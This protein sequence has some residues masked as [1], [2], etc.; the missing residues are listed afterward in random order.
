MTAQASLWQQETPVC[1]MGDLWRLGRHTLLVGDATDPSAL[2]RLMGETRADLL[3]CDPP[4]GM[5]LDTWDN[6]LPDIPAWVGLSASYLSA[7]G[8]LLLCQVMPYVL[9]WLV[10]LEASPL[11]FKDHISWVKRMATTAMLPLNRAHESLYIYARPH[12]RYHQTKGRYTDVK[13]PGLLVDTMSLEGIDRHI[14]A[15]E[16]EI[17]S[18]EREITHAKENKH[19]AYRHMQGTK[20]VRAPEMANFTNVWSFLPNHAAH[21]PSKTQS[22]T[23]HHATVKPL[24]LVTRAVELCTPPDGTVL[25]PFAGSGTSFI[26]CE[27]S[28]RTCYGVELSP[29][30]AALILGRWAQE[31]GQAVQRVTPAV[32]LSLPTR[33]PRPSRAKAKEDT[34]S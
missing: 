8:F 22:L 1:Q 24:P 16:H 13:L 34:P 31:T 30:Y 11:R 3:F 19:N 6:P 21:R 18:G 26:A 32:I 15:L 10:A 9:P 28:G 23:R 7:Q 27:Q 14:K 20:S 2:Q 12:A 29:E 25:D 4:Y 17:R 33:K 5:H